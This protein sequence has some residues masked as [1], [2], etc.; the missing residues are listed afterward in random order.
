MQDILLCHKI[1]CHN[2]TLE[3]NKVKS[4][5]KS[6]KVLEVLQLNLNYSILKV[7]CYCFNKTLVV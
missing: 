2:N 4:L 6:L 5:H 7:F 1:L 3:S